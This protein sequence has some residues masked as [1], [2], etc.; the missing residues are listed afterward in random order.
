MK[1]N[2]NEPVWGHTGADPGISTFMLFNPETRIGAIVLASRF[3]DIR[4]LQ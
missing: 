3:V 2:N 1:L 4:D